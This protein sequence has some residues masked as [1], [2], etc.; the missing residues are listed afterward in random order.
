M[1]TLEIFR[2]LSC[3]PCLI[4]RISP[5]ESIFEYDASYLESPDA[6]PLSL[7]LPLRQEPFKEAHFKPYFEGLI[8][9]GAARRTLAAELQTSESDYLSILELCG[10]ECIG[11]IVV[12]EEGQPFVG[13]PESY[14]ALLKSEFKALFKNDCEMA[15]EN[16][17]SRLSLAGTQNKIG[18]AH[19]PS[20]A[21]DEGW[22]RPQG[23]AGTTHI[24]K[25]SHLLD[26][27]ELEYLCM[28]TAAQLGIP[29]AKVALL[30]FGKPVLVVERFDRIVRN[31]ER[32]MQV[33]RL[34]QEDLAQALGIAPGS[35]YVELSGSTV[36]CIAE[37]LK[38]ESAQPARDVISFAQ[39][40]CFSYL[41]GNCDAHLK[42]FS[43]V[44]HEGR[45]KGKPRT[46]LAPAY[47]FVSTT[48]FPR[49]SRD[50][51]F[52]LGGERDIDAIS[53]DNFHALA[54]QLGISESSLR[55]LAKPL[56]NEIV[57]A[58]R[59]AGNGQM[60]AVLESTPYIADRLEE[61]LQPRLDVLRSFC[62]V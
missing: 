5:N 20:A 30:D 12:H 45:G 17:A 9:E 57:P 13:V 59:K 62:G 32:N 8:A 58:L 44:Y 21:M 4:G 23:F 34:H 37:L 39:Q 15:N 52:A 46:S 27:P 53:P 35:K 11:D 50:M 48:Y 54:L 29:T 40:I 22:F 56:V 60:G 49:F 16:I 28:K 10:R 61:D 38:Q 18:L 41:I 31:T 3:K 47:D 7:S 14:E 26:V 19:L 25:T 36:S 6:Q 24:L 55:N 51:A 33:T 43:I 42:N 2:L 1:R